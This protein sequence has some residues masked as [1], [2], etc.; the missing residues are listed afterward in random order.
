MTNFQNSPSVGGF[1]PLA[2]E[3]LILINWSYW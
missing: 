3:V 2:P 1:P